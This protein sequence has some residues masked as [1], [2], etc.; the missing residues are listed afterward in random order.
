M[1]HIKWSDEEDLR[2]LEEVASL[3]LN[4][5][6]KMLFSIAKAHG[7]SRQSILQRIRYLQGVTVSE[8]RMFMGM[9]SAA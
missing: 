7:R 9:E 4:Y 8:M 5:P 6:H 3:P 2:L 1:W